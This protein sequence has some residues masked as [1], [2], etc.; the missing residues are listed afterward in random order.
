MN[1]NK[2]LSLI[3]YLIIMSRGYSLNWQMHAKVLI[4]INLDGY[5]TNART[6][7][8]VFA[9]SDILL[10]RCDDDRAKYSERYCRTNRQTDRLT[11]KWKSEMTWC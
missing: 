3:A 6:M 9:Y 8:M 4:K 10:V 7:E 2:E 11:G 5:I 1:K